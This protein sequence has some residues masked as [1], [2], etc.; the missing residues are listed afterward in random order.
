M[1]KLCWNQLDGQ[2]AELLEA[3]GKGGQRDQKRPLRAFPESFT[4]ASSSHP[5]SDGQGACSKPL[6]ARRDRLGGG[7]RQNPRGRGDYLQTLSF[8]IVSIPALSPWRTSLDI[9]AK[10]WAKLW[11]NKAVLG[12]YLLVIQMKT[13]F[14]LVTRML[15]I[16]NFKDNWL[17]DR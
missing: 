13:L 3:S 7:T 4:A 14:F 5:E 1:E 11:D 15:I 17:W 16:I 12:I 8:S 6:V 9:T 2:A 10:Q